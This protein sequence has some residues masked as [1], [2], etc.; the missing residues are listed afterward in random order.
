M[1][2]ENRVAIVTGAAQ[3]IGRA[4][5]IELARAGTN[6]VIA[7]IQKDKTRRVVPAD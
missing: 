7:D 3:N 1:D 2:L 5:A 6:I 4:I